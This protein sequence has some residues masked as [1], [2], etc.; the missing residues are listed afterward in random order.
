MS[1]GDSLC[2]WEPKSNDP[3]DADFATFDAILTTSA[4]EPDD[5]I[6]VYDF[7]PGAT[8]EYLVLPGPVMPKHYGGGGVTLDI[9]FMCEATSGNVKVDAAFK[10]LSAGVNLLT[11]TYAAVNTDTVAVNATARVIFKA[12]IT[13]TDGADMDSVSAGNPFNLLITRDS[14]DAADTV[15]SN[16]LEFFR[17]HLFET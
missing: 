6:P 5:V 1:S 3:P 9:W 4:D 10:D 2:A 13:F 7:D 12:T 16:D 14:A 15:N 11:A 17:A 8:Q